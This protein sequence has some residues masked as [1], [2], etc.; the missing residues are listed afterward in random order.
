M[1]RFLHNF[2][3]SSS[4]PVSLLKNPLTVCLMDPPPD[5]WPPPPPPPTGLAPLSLRRSCMT[6]PT[7]SSSTLTILLIILQSSEFV[8]FLAQVTLHSDALSMIVNDESTATAHAVVARTG[9]LALFF[10]SSFSYATAARTF[11]DAT[12]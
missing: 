5:C 6:M 2:F 9:Q 3:L 1:L 8:H 11:A 12:V 4:L 7:R 10:L